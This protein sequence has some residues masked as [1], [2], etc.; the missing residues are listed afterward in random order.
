MLFIIVVL[1]AFWVVVIAGIDAAEYAAQTVIGRDTK[2]SDDMQ[3]VVHLF[4]VEKGHSQVELII[5]RL[6]WNIVCIHITNTLRIAPILPNQHL[7]GCLDR[8]NR[9][10]FI[11]RE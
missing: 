10:S 11:T 8:H 3:C 9:R 7:Q 1:V 2:Q 5:A 6:D 4:A